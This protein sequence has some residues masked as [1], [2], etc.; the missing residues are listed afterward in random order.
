VATARRRKLRTVRPRSGRR[1]AARS[2]RDRR[3]KPG[4]R[5]QLLAGVS[6]FL[7]EKG[8]GEFSFRRAADAAG[9]SA[10][11][12][13]HY[14]GTK[15]RLVTEALSNISAGWIGSVFD[16]ER[17]GDLGAFDD[18]YWRSWRSFT[19]DQYLQHLRLMYEVLSAAFRNPAP[20]RQVLETVTVGWQSRFADSLTAV[21]VPFDRARLISTF[22]LAALRGLL[23]D[24]LATGDVE[25]VTDA[26]GLVLENLK[27][28]VL[29][30]LG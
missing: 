9:T 14:F 13:V 16:Q 15:D 11:L 23:L 18:L 20:F 5:E 2:T 4:R 28:D 29:S 6:A 30:A 10:Q 19:S 3:P 26:A 27:R 17:M 12:L 8:L 25:R 7:L 1:P 21:G 24:L 22:Y